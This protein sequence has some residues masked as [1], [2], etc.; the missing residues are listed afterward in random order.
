VRASC[1]VGNASTPRIQRI[2]RLPASGP[3][4]L[5]L[6]RDPDHDF[7][8]TTAPKVAALLSR[9]EVPL[10]IDVGDTPVDAKQLLI[11]GVAT[12]DIVDGV[13]DEYIEASKKALDAD[14]IEEFERSVR[15]FYDQM[16]LIRI[17]PQSARFFD[18]GAGRMPRFLQNLT[19]G[20]QA[21]N[22]PR[23]AA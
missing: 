10:T 17:R 7:T 15:S 12:V 16:A 13:P 19:S 11:R 5:L 9:P 8:A 21:A 1:S 14:Q 3:G 23:D 2:G 20:G 4:R 18:F 22:E 6:G